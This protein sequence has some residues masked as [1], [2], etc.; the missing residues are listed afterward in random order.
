MRNLKRVL[1]LA[2]ASVMLMGMMVMGAGAADT[3]KTAGDLTDMDKVSNKEAVTLLVDLG[4]VEGKTDGSF[5]P[6]ETVNRATMAKLI[7]IMMMGDVDPSSFAG[8]STD[9]TDVNGHWAEG[10]IKY[11]YSNKIIA[12]D[13]AGHFFP[14]Q[15]VT[16]VQAAKMLLVAI[17]FD[18]KD[19]KYENDSNWSINIMRDA[20]SAKLED[21][22]TTRALTKGVSLKANDSLSR[23]NAAQMIFNTLFVG[24][25]AP[26]YQWDNGTQYIQEYKY[27]ASMADTTYGG[28][29]RVTGTLTAYNATT[30][31]ATILVKGTSKT[32]KIA[33]NSSDIGSNV[34][35]YTDTAGKAVSTAAVSSSTEILGTSM[36]GTSYTATLTKKGEKG[37]VAEEDDTKVLYY[38]NGAEKAGASAKTDIDTLSKFPG[39]IVDMIDTDGDGDIDLVKVLQKTVAELSGEIVTRTYKEEEQVSVPGVTSSYVATSKVHGYEG[40]KK[41]D[42][43]LFYTTGTGT[44]T[45]YFIEA[46]ESVTGTIGGYKG[47]TIKV[48]G[49][50]YGF[51]KVT[52]A[53]DAKKVTTDG[54]TDLAN[55]DVENEYT[56]VLDNG[57]NIAFV[58]KNTDETT[59]DIAVVLDIAD[60]I[61]GGVG[62]QGYVEAQFL[63]A[64]GTTVVGTV[65]KVGVKDGTT[66]KTFTSEDI[67]QFGFYTYKIDSKGKYEI[68]AADSASVK[69]VASGIEIKNGKTPVGSYTANAKTVYLV[70]K[71]SGSDV[72]YTTYTGFNSVPGMTT[73]GSNSKVMLVKDSTTV[74]KYVYLETGSF[75]GDSENASYVYL[76]DPTAF[77][78][79]AKSGDV[80]AHYDY[81]AIIDGEK[82]TL[83]VD[84]KLTGKTA[85]LYKDVKMIDGIADDASIDTALT[86]VAYDETKHSVGN[87][88]VVLGAGAENVYTYDSDTVVYMIAVGEDDADVTKTNCD[89]VSFSNTDLYDYVL[90]QVPAKS[91][92]QLLSDLYIIQTE[93]PAPVV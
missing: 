41:G 37:F 24:T 46:T 79:V 33:A 15:P 17:G 28:L 1:S 89:S 30:G 2:L 68:T 8:T 29:E 64:D 80:P 86:G 56:F 18:A 82:D 90:I 36:D 32:V 21:G 13:G 92:E 44:S 11:C 40:L 72:T 55:V 83:S 54:G 20:Q 77:T 16:T 58:T 59:G 19:R 42:V 22:K 38:V 27:A 62:K 69:T 4:I 87:G 71:G 51:S 84:A 25:V 5:A 35:Y 52:S 91:G 6:A 65:S 34:V 73:T 75:V 78:Y 14:D 9:L 3:K 88:V 63:L 47:A 12:G 60:V 67:D 26:T 43:V 39:V 48:D 23:D 57:G 70:A 10:Y 74:A 85:G 61:G 45:E 93:K 53:H 81:A 49:A 66:G 7:T 31:S 76:I 50:Y